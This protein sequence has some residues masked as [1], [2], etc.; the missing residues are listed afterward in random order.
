MKSLP[1][2]LTM[3]FLFIVT[4]LASSCTT[5]SDPLDGSSWTLTSYRKTSPIEGTVITASFSDGNVSGSLGCNHYG[6]TYQVKG[7]NIS[8]EVIEMTLMACLEP[9]GA[10]EQEQLLAGYLMDVN[11]FMIEDNRLFLYFD[12]HEALTFERQVTP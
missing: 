12:S 8:F 1:V 6:T 9:E 5:F 7:D 3:I 2:L 4:F 11:S 10:M